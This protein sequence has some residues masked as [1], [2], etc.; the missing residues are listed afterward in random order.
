LRAFAKLRAPGA[1]QK[2]GHLAFGEFVALRL[3]DEA[4]DHGEAEARLAHL[5]NQN[6]RINHCQVLLCACQPAALAG[7]LDQFPVSALSRSA[8]CRGLGFVLF[9]LAVLAAVARPVT[10]TPG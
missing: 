4:L 2:R 6:V 10:S 9:V 3:L 5:R 1:E 8:L 7:V